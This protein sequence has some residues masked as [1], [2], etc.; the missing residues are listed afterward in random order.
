M[1]Y[2]DKGFR[3]P[4]LRMYPVK[5]GNAPATE[6]DHLGVSTCR[7]CGRQPTHVAYGPYGPLCLADA[8]IEESRY[9]GRSEEDLLKEE[10][11]SW[12][13]PEPTSG[14]EG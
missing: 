10:E 5:I 7:S 2:W 8:L 9:E 3:G 6:I 12:K 11:E 4:E 14:S 13:S 1:R